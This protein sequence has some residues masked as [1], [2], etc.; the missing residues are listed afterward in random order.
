V[1]TLFASICIIVVAS[2]LI[3]WADIRGPAAASLVI[4]ACNLLA[5]HIVRLLTSFESHRN[6]SLKT[7]SQYYKIT[8]FRWSF[9]V[10]IPL[11]ITPFLNILDDDAIIENI[12]VLFIAE[13]IQRP[14]LQT[15]NIVGLLK[16]H[17]LGPRAQD[18]RRMNL[19]YSG[20]KYHIAE[21][22][23]DIT[24]VL[25]LTV[26]YCVVYPMAFFFAS[27]IFS[28]YYWVDKFLILRSW[29]QG[30]KI[31]TAVCNLS[32]LFFKICLFAY[33]MMASYIYYQFPYDNACPSDDT[34][35]HL[36]AY[37]GDI[38][39]TTARGD[40]MKETL[41]NVTTTRG[42][43]FC[44]EQIPPQSILPPLSWELI[45]DREWMDG[46]QKMYSYVFGWTSVGVLVLVFASLVYRLLMT[47]VYPL[48]FKS[49][50]VRQEM[51]ALSMDMDIYIYI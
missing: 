37:V 41:K 24:K 22:Y 32:I 19:L 3:K 46:S 34:E 13:M 49:Y 35:Q 50:T 9:T 25:L 36:S 43:K 33:A 2:Y 1:G 12:K 14:I 15:V 45:N 44:D 51:A 42:Y 21:R 30:P 29:K 11:L 27:V 39:V 38:D 18:Q 16:R 26:F 28:I 5:P 48:F 47:S 20:D 17:I 7:A 6:E 10:F 23:T 31:G 8:A 40:G 4:V